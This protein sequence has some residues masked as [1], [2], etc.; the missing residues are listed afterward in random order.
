MASKGP[1]RPGGI[2]SQVRGKLDGRWE[3]SVRLGTIRLALAIL[4]SLVLGSAACT[5]SGREAAGGRRINRRGR[6]GSQ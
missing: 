6:G 2:R 3:A 1:R 5:D 4:A